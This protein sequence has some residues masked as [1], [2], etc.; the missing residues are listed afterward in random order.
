MQLSKQAIEDFRRIYKEEYGEEISEE[1][2]NKLG[3]NLLNF[4]KI[5]LKKP[6]NTPNNQEIYERSNE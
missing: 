3:V 2:A 4:Y 5:I 6:P 1:E